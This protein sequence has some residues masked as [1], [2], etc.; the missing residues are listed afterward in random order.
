MGSLLGAE[1]CKCVQR[2]AVLIFR[3]SAVTNYLG[4][5]FGGE[6]NRAGAAVGKAGVLVILC[7]GRMCWQAKI[8]QGERLPVRKCW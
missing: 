8:V 1:M 2:E 7:A 4:G 6:R 3:L 5:C